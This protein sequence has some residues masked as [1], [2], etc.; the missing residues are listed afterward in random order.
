MNLCLYE[1]PDVGAFGPL[2]LLRPVFSLRCGVFSLV[3]KLVRAFP[4]APLVLVVRPE[5]EELTRALY[6]TAHVG[7]PP[8]AETLFVNARLCMTDDEVLHFL[9]ASPTEASYMAGGLLFAAKVS[10]PRVREAARK[11]RAG[12]PEQAFAELR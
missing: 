6:P 2:A 9:A 8:E 11:L 7:E 12:D 4:E 3:E 5:I 10:A 1:D